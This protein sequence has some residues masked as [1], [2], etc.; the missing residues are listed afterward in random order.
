MRAMILAAGRGQR[1]GTLTT[2]APK[3]LLELNGV[4]LIEHQLGRLAAAGVDVAV[5]NL[6]YRGEQIRSVVGDGRRFG[7][8]VHFS[9]EGPE[10]LETAGG[11][12]HA[13]PLLGAE[14]FLVVNADVVSDFD[15]Q[16]LSAVPDLG[17]LVLVPNPPHKLRGDYGIGPDSRLSH[18][19]PLL[20]FSG[21]SMLS[22]DLFVG[23][24]P[25]RRPL[26]Q[27]F[28]AG[29]AAR[30]L[31][32]RVHEGLWI[33]AGTPERLELARALFRPST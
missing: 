13:L 24:E 20:T 21:I 1:M 6:S 26:S 25:G 14:P 16:S 10:P 5:I 12:V 29:I 19:E 2:T 33:D 22:P 28:D 23:L 31:R 8:S 15:L 9:D 4:T 27:V 3:P 18:D 17:T 11:I 7:L 32:A 30:T